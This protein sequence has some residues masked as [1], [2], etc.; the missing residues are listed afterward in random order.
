[1]T[2]STKRARRPAIESFNPMRRADQQRRKVCGVDDKAIDECIV[3]LSNLSFLEQ[4]RAATSTKPPAAL[5][6]PV[7]EI[8]NLAQAAG[9]VA[10]DMSAGCTPA[11]QGKTR[12]TRTP[13]VARTLVSPR[14]RA[15]PSQ[16]NAAWIPSS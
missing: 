8:G 12:E 13:E 10:A 9:D 15:A 2:L 1:L 4:P 5:V 11:V 3:H 7:A 16:A 6:V 14:P